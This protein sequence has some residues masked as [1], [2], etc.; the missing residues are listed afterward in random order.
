MS[1]AHLRLSTLPQACLVGSRGDLTQPFDRVITDTRLVTDGTGVCFVAIRGARHDG[2]R[3]LHQAVSRGVRFFIV[4]DASEL[5][6]FDAVT[7]IE[8][9][10]SVQALQALAAQHRRQFT[11]EVFAIT[12]S[13]GKTIVKEWLYQLLAPD[14]RI[15]RSPRSYNS[16][17]GVPL[18]VLQLQETDELALFE[19]GISHPNEMRALAEVIQPKFGIL[20]HI[21]EAHRENFASQRAIADEKCVLFQGCEVVFFR[22][23]QPDGLAALNAL[24]FQGRRVTWAFNN[25]NAD[26]NCSRWVRGDAHAQLT[27]AYKG[28]EACVDIPFTDVHAVCNALTCITVM[29]DRGY[30]FKVIAQRVAELRPLELRMERMQGVNNSTL[31]TDVWNNDLNALEVALDELVK[32]THAKRRVLILSD[33]LQTGVAPKALY[34]RVNSLLQNHRIDL[35][36][37]VGSDL[38]AAQAVFTIPARFYANTGAL[39]HELDELVFSDSAVL[40]KGASHFKFDR[41]VR[42]LQSMA[43]SSVLE[44]NLTRVVANYNFYKSR[45]QGDTRVMAM[46]KAFGYGTG[47]VEL[48]STL[49]FHRVDYFGVAYVSEGVAL[50]AAGIATPIFVLSPDAAGMPALIKH[51][52]EPEIYSFRI[53]D[54]LLAEISTHDGVTQYPIHIKID[55]GMHRLG[56]ALHELAALAERLTRETR[57]RVVGVLS[58]F[59]AADDAAFDAFTRQ[60]IA[61][62]KEGAAQLEAAL[63]HPIMRHICNTSGLLR[64]PEAHFDMV[65][66]GIGLYGVP[67]CPVDAPH[68]LP[69][70]SLKTRISQIHTI[71]SGESVG[72]GRGDLADHP[73]T[74]ATVPVGYADGYPRHLSKGKGWAM[75]HG[76]SAPVVGNVC[77]DMTMLDVTDLPCSEGDEVQLFGDAPTLGE[78]AVAAG[79]I[80]YEIIAGIS[81]RVH[82]VYYYE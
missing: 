6:E 42:R 62:F 49:A 44:I 73:R 41:V 25:P 28:M 15:A 78:L 55:T 23:D 34:T 67:A 70:G 20:T 77:M 71:A 7:F 37:A 14:F 69:A 31:I 64:F 12:G 80:P 51:R 72:Y 59:S 21:G 82:R 68:I 58:H 74:I 5:L 36:I 8:V 33:I 45:L 79:T 32:I 47:G 4:E 65:R 56:F 30:D 29:L 40:I 18:S 16:Q 81:Q 26:L 9:K 3:Y 61:Q 10:H 52:L 1:K 13:N 75:I 63:G 39:L 11:A 53:L 19:A 24:A 66:L 17:I 76:K 43:H 38:H 2:H 46:V 54:T 50:R 27:L 60:Q 35:L 57:V 48:A 22:L